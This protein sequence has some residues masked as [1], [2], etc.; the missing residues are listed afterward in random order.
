[1]GSGLLVVISGPSGSG[2]TTLCQ[3]ALERIEGTKY[4]ISF[5]ARPPRGDE[6]DGKDYHFVTK[7]EF[8]RMAKEGRFA[9]WANVHGNYY[10]TPK[11]FLER[12]IREGFDLF[13]DIDVQG[14][15]QIKER[16]GERAILVYVVPPSLE[17]LETRLRGR[18]VDEE[19]VIKRRLINAREELKYMLRYDYWIVSR[20][21]ED[22]VRILEGILTAERQRMGRIP[23]SILDKLGIDGA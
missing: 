14:G 16:Y 11:S 6:V 18:A 17:E 19:E 4:S 2:K 10:G 7:D 23:K 22:S 8:E 1:M 3:R 21:V 13:L 15:I 9:E 20:D 12:A 5:T